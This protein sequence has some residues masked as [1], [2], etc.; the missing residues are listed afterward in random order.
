[1][2]RT[3]AADW[4][5]LP[6]E[7]ARVT[8]T[9]TAT[10]ADADP[11]TRRRGRRVLTLQRTRFPGLSVSADAAPPE[12][13]TV[14]RVALGW[15]VLADPAS[16]AFADDGDQEALTQVGWRGAAARVHVGGGR[17][18]LVGPGWSVDGRTLEV[19]DVGTAAESHRALLSPGTWV[20]RDARGRRVVTFQVRDR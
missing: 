14:V 10:L 11:A 1:V 4:V 6:D 17:L 18:V 12:V 19:D 8:A 5:G 20:I 13:P 15:P 16:A 3:A 7:A 9:L 2:E